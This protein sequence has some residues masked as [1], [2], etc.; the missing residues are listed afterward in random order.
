MT[1]RR[2]G[3]P[4]IGHSRRGSAAVEPYDGNVA[5][6]AVAPASASVSLV[7]HRRATSRWTRTQGRDPAVK[8]GAA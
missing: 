7:I 6:S 4:P 2:A 5:G 8:E 3:R 1:V